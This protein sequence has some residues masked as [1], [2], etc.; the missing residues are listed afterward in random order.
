MS[1]ILLI[2]DHVLFAQALKSI[3]TRKKDLNI[4][5]VLRSGEEALEKLP[6]LH[7]D[8]VIADV[9]Y[10]PSHGWYRPC[11]ANPYEISMDCLFDA[12]GS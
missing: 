3:L 4:A 5:A 12:L 1:S 7:V 8:L 2:E 6:E 11:S 9:S 10:P